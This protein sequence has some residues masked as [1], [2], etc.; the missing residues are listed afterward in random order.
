MRHRI[1]A[2][3]CRLG[4]HSHR[5]T[6]VNELVLWKRQQIMVLARWVGGTVL[7]YVR[8]APTCRMN[9]AHWKI[10][11]ELLGFCKAF[12]RKT[13]TLDERSTA[14]MVTLERISPDLEKIRRALLVGPYVLKVSDPRCK[15]HRVPRGSFC[16][17]VNLRVQGSGSGPS[18]RNPLPQ[19]SHWMPEK[20]T[21]GASHDC[22]A[23]SI[24]TDGTI[25]AVFLFFGVFRN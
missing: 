10:S 17:C 3:A 7:R 2:T 24:V 23:T 18:R 13:S 1:Q 20:P 12:Q 11:I 9:F 21:F 14:Q 6:E 25:V 8:D 16:F 19:A 15:W 5:V 4:G 22:G